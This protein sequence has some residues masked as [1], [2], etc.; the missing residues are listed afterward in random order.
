MKNDKGLFIKNPRFWRIPRKKKKKIPKD[1]FYCYTPTSEPGNMDD[2]QWGYT[3]DT[4]TFSTYVKIKDIKRASW[5]DDEYVEEFG[6][7]EEN[8]C[9]LTKGIIDDQCKICGSRY[10]KW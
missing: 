1:T 6:E 4:C 5:M 8:V 10:G 3:I 2:G 7:I 9:K